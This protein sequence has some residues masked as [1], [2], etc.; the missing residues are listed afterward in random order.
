MDLLRHIFNKHWEDYCK[1]YAPTQHQKN[2]IEKMMNCS[3]QSCNSRICSSCGKRY[4]DKW[5][6]FIV[7]SL[8]P[9]P[10]THVVLTI[11]ALL[12]IYFRSWK[13]L[14]M[15]LKCSRDFLAA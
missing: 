6:N 1:S 4:A 14:D 12:R 13:N 3:K 8:A 10:K 2:E 5:S 7:K 11:P 15:L 9:V